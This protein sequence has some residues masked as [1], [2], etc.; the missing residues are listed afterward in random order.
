M[1][2]GGHDSALDAAA[3]YRHLSSAGHET[4]VGALLSEL[5]YN[6]AGFA[7]P[8]ASTEDAR[9]G[10]WPTWRHLHHRQVLDD[11][12]EARTALKR[13]MS[14]ANLARVE[15]LQQEVIKSGMGI[16]DDSDF[17]DA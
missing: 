11:L 13:D 1:T 4:M 8:D 17:D 5:I 15:A 16:A 12:N 9:N 2:D 10:W 3:L 14:E 6:H 7:R